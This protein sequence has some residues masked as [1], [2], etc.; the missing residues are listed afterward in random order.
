MAGRVLLDTEQRNWVSDC[1]K[2]AGLDASAGSHLTGLIEGSIAIFLAARTCPAGTDREAHDALRELWFMAHEKD[3]PIGQLRARV[4]RLPAKAL[5]YIDSR[6][7][8]VVPRLFPGQSA[9]SGFQA[10]ARNADGPDLVEALRTLSAD[11]GRIVPGRSRGRGKRSKGKLEPMIGAQVRGIGET[12]PK[13]GRPAHANQDNL[14]MH[15]AIDWCKAT[16]QSPEDGRS[17]TTGFGEVVHSVFDWVGEPG[18]TQ[19]LRRYWTAVKSAKMTPIP[20]GMVIR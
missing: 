1:L 12:A 17:D 20:G 10:W 3:S 6:A 2:K 8:H 18:A 19:A 9:D 13:G 14:V 5:S 7:A 16:G 4:E 11:G 15:L